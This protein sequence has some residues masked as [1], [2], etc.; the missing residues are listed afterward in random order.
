MN[1]KNI[2]LT[3]T[4]PKDGRNKTMPECPHCGMCTE[5]PV[6]KK[7]PL[8]TGPATCCVQKFS[9]AEVERWLE[10][11][12]L[13]GLT[14]ENIALHNAVALLRDQEDGIEAS[15]IRGCTTTGYAN[16]R[17]LRRVKYGNVN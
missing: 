7:A 2:T 9:L 11:W 14:K 15:T 4:V 17:D 8:G 3:L 10:G 16:G 6:E 12:E 13:L 1:G 5:Q